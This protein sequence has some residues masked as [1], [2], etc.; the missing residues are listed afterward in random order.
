VKEIADG[1]ARNFLI[2]K[3][4]VVPATKD[5]EARVSRMKIE[6]ADMKK[7]DED[8]LI[9]NLK[10]LIGLNIAMKGKANEKGHLFAAI[11][12]KEIISKIHDEAKLQIPPECILLEKP[13][14]E[15]GEHTISFTMGNKT[16]TFTVVVENKD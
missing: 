13:I 15:I 1:F 9:R 7:V 16:G 6:L 5:A 14:K 10:A 4:L 3:K 8:L 2:P 12:K 11:H